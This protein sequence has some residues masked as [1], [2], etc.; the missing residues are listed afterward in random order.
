MEA[1]APTGHSISEIDANYPTTVILFFFIFIIVLA[2]LFALVVTENT[3]IVD[4]YIAYIQ[5]TAS[6]G[7]LIAAA[8]GMGTVTGF[9]LSALRD[10]SGGGPPKE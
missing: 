6:L 2:I 3:Q 5:I 9:I 10:L 4:L 8:F 7:V 1:R